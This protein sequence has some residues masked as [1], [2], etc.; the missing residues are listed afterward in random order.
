MNP[1]KPIYDPA[2]GDYAGLA[3]QDPDA[4]GQLDYANQHPIWSLDQVYDNEVRNRI[5]GSLYTDVELLDGLVFHTMGSIDWSFNRMKIVIHSTLLMGLLIEMKR[6]LKLKFRPT[7]K[8]Y[9]VH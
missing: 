1:Y 2:D 3:A 7:R 4:E 9:L 5:W 6:F 8:P